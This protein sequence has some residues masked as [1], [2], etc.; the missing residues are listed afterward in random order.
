[1]LGNLFIQQSSCKKPRTHNQVFLVLVF[2]GSFTCLCYC[3]EQRFFPSKF[4]LTSSIFLCMYSWIDGNMARMR[5]LWVIWIRWFQL[6]V[7]FSVTTINTN[8]FPCPK[9][10]MTSLWTKEKFVNLYPTHEQIQLV[11]EELLK[12]N[13]VV[14]ARLT[15]QFTV[16]LY[17]TGMRVTQSAARV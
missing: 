2:L 5:R 11:K 13:L 8:N 10:G 1:M 12:V 3:N 17:Q 16:C 14:C 15:F 6:F 9:A 4:S 7:N